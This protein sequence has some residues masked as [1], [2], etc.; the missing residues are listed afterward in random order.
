MTSSDPT[1]ATATAQDTAVAGTHSVV[2]SQLA[3]TSSSYSDPIADPTSLAGTTLT[4]AYGDANNPTKTDSIA[5]PS[6]VKTVAS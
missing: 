6:T 5:L 4:I 1:I 2:V 3:T